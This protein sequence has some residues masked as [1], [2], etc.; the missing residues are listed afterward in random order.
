VRLRFDEMTFCFERIDRSRENAFSNGR[1]HVPRRLRPNGEPERAQ[2][3]AEGGDPRS[4]R[5]IR[6][7][8]INRRGPTRGRAIESRPWP[9]DRLSID[10]GTGRCGLA[11][12]RRN[13]RPFA[14]L[15]DRRQRSP[16]SF[17]V[18]AVRSGVRARG[19]R[20]RLIQTAARFQ[21]G[22]PRADAIRYVCRLLARNEASKS[23]P[24]AAEGGPLTRPGGRAARQIRSN[25]QRSRRRRARIL[26][27]R[28]LVC[29]RKLLL[30]CL[31]L[32]N[33]TF[34][35]TLE[36]VRGSLLARTQLFP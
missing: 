4:V 22:R 16:P 20:E 21:A 11:R 19:L 8:S 6:S 26:A 27:A 25:H 18:Y 35:H 32:G 2:N 30:F 5:T 17:C 23:A 33:Q 36:S 10:Q 7:S 34:H 13:T 1:R 28:R 12:R 15:R 29:P 14:L 9:G 3:P 31:P 24:D